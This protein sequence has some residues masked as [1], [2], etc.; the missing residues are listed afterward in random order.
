MQLIINLNFPF[1]RFHGREFPPSPSRFFQSLIA[2]S[3]RGIYELQNAEIRDAALDWLETLAPP[4][5]ESSYYKLSGTNSTNYVPNNDN[6]FSHN[7]TAKSLQAFV[8]TD[9]N[10]LRFVWNFPNDAEN[11]QNAETICK[12]A[13]LVTNLGHGQDAVF[14]RGEIVEDSEL[15]NETSTV[16]RP[17]LRDGANW[18]APQKG[19]LA[20]YK[21]RY[22]AFLQTGN[23]HIINAAVRQIEYISDDTI[24]LTYP[25]ALFEMRKL[26]DDEEF[27]SFDGRDSRQPAAMVRHAVTDIFNNPKGERFRRYYG[28]DIISRKIFGHRTHSHS[29]DKRCADEAHLAFIPIPN[30]Y[31]DGKIRRVLLAGFNFQDES[32]LELFEDI[33]GN[34]NGAEIKDNGKPKAKLIRIENQLKDSIFPLEKTAK[35]WRSVTPVIMSGF[36]RRGRTP[37]HLI[38]RALNQIG[39]GNKSVESVAAFRAPIVP[40]TFRPKQYKIAENDYLNETPRYHAEVVFKYPVRGVLVIGRGRHAGFGLMMPV[41]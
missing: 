31:P 24:D 39:I 16:F 28:E 26:D 29:P 20:S 34:L 40:K 11:K 33:T 7:R 15:S 10:R 14:V 37:E 9:E 32:E 18:T 25:Y 4:I 30:L 13:R 2:G 27:Y 12:M 19:A 41:E 38:Y 36:T 23:S 8:L 6:S 17:K 5:I 1:G 21:R 22:D 3:H 35:V